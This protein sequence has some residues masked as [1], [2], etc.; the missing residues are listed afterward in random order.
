[1]FPSDTAL[2][3]Q[4]NIPL[5]QVAEDGTVELGEALRRWDAGLVEADG[6]DRYWTWLLGVYG[7]IEESIANRPFD[8]A[9]NVLNTPL[10]LYQEGIAWLRRAHDTGAAAISVIWMSTW[11]RART[12]R[13]R[14][15]PC[16]P[17]SQ[18]GP[19][20]LHS[21]HLPGSRRSA[22]SPGVSPQDTLELHRRR[23]APETP[24]RV[25]IGSP[26]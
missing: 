18:D 11:M 25:L 26:R 4:A 2:W 21:P 16:F 8:S 9:G 24:A 13:R 23:P 12:R 10:R 19:D 17:C 15:R 3:W 5:F 6:I 14:Q 1:M 20:V 7:A 22:T